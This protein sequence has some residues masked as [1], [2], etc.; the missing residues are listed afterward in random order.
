MRKDICFYSYIFIDLFFI[1]TF[2][3]CKFAFVGQMADTS[4]AIETLV[5]RFDNH[6]WSRFTFFSIKK[7]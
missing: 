7:E 3:G 4:L 1:R 2:G 6:V 5:Q